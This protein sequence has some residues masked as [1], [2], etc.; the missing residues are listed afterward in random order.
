VDHLGN[1]V[2]SPRF[3]QVPP[4]QDEDKVVARIGMGMF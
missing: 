1:Q 2:G 4:C 3:P